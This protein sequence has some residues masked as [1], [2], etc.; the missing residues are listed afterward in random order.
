MKS[1]PPLLSNKAEEMTI[2]DDPMEKTTV[3]FRFM[4]NPEYITVGKYLIINESGLK[5]FGKI[6]EVMND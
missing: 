4:Y 2:S 3:M 1:D 6:T 5:A